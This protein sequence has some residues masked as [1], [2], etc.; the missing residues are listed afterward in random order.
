MSRR[1]LKKHLRHRFLVNLKNGEVFEGLLDRHDS[2][3]LV[4]VDAVQIV[5]RGHTIEH[6]KASSEVWLRWVNVAYMQKTGG[7]T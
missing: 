4:L 1:L 5:E 7:Q 2:E 6:V 3:H